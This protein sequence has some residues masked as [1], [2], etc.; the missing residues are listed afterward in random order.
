MAAPR[1]PLIQRQIMV[2]RLSAAKP[3]RSF[4]PARRPRIPRGDFDNQ[5]VGVFP[6][7]MSTRLMP[8]SGRRRVTVFT[9][10]PCRPSAQ[11]AQPCRTRS[12]RPCQFFFHRRS[13][14]HRMKHRLF[15]KPGDFRRP[16]FSGSAIRLCGSTFVAALLK[17]AGLCRLGR[18]LDNEFLQRCPRSSCPL[19]LVQ[20]ST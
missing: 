18:G 6:R 12:P 17:S 14:S 15:C 2:L 16:S 9:P 20:L 8:W 5:I 4:F 10:S 1:F 3:N 13:P 7:S 19:Q 11:P